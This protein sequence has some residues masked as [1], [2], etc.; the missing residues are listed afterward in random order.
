M[1]VSG[2]GKSTIAALVAERLGWIFVDGDSFHTPEHIAKMHAG[3]ALDDEDRAPWLAA[4][5]VW[6]RHRLAAGESGVI[7]CS[8]LRRTYRDVLTGGSACVRVVYLDGSRALIA[9]RLAA[10]HG[11]FMPSTLLDSQ[12]AVLEP[13]GPD[14]YP[15]VVAIDAEPEAIVACILAQV[16]DAGVAGPGRSGR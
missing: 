10:R 8:A 11:H 2:S 5:A 7:V 6:I 1:G 13:P 4:I 16:R 14:E 3:S 9:G 15:I 12:F